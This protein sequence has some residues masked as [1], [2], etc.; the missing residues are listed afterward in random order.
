MSI[1]M[2]KVAIISIA[3]SAMSLAH[4]Q[5]APQQGSGGGAAE[6]GEQQRSA[7]PQ[8]GGG[9]SAPDVDLSDKEI[10]KFAK[11]QSEVKSVREEYSG[12]LNNVEDKKKARKIQAEMQREMQQV[13]KD[14]G[15]ST[16]KYN[17]VQQASMR[18]KDVRKRVKNAME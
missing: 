17:K 9:R 11:A 15:M 14:A 16:A 10:Q 5:Q 6:R 2:L 7:P 8:A 12:K 4:A 1:R 13:V 18:D 3:A